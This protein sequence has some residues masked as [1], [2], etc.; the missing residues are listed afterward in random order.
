MNEDL[1]K[2]FEDLYD[3]YEQA[4]SNG[5]IS[6]DDFDR[7]DSILSIVWKLDEP[8]S[9]SGIFEYLETNEDK[10]QFIEDFKSAVDLVNDMET[11]EDLAEKIVLFR[12]MS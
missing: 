2:K 5:D 8:A 10:S 3:Y 9:I 4:I 12:D 1:N 6:G 7:L 11:D